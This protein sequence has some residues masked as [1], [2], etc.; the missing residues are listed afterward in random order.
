[1]LRSLAKSTSFCRKEK[2]Q[3]KQRLLKRRVFSCGIVLSTMIFGAVVAPL[4]AGT[5][6]YITPPGSTVPPAPG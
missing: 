4:H 5:I 3:M 2:F 6:T 1:M